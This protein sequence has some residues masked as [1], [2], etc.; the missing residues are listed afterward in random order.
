MLDPCGPHANVAIASSFPGKGA[1]PSMITYY[2]VNDG[3]SRSS[4][5]GGC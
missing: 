4:L 2:T 1:W 3:T 5:A